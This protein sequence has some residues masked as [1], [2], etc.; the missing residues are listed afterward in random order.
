MDQALA[1]GDNGVEIRRS[2][3]ICE[4]LRVVRVK[5]LAGFSRDEMR[6]AKHPAELSRLP[7][8]ILKG[9]MPGCDR[10]HAIEGIGV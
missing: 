8:G 5:S 1:L 9:V 6:Q 10:A 2:D 4:R 7:Q 3:K